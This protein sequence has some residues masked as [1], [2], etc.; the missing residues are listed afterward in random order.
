MRYCA[1][2]AGRAEGFGDHLDRLRLGLRDA[3]ARFRLALGGENRATA[4]RL[5]R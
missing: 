5:R 4:S 3:Q 1:G 2:L